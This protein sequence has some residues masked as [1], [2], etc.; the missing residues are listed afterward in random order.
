MNVI[1]SLKSTLLE[2]RILK[3]L[4]GKILPSERELRD[5]FEKQFAFQKRSSCMIL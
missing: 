1:L 3:R 5:E 2:K 4:S